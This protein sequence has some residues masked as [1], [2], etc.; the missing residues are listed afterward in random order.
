MPKDPA[1]LIYIDKWLVSTKS[2][3]AA[4][5]GWY[6]SLILVQYDRGGE[7]PNDIEELAV[8]CDVRFSEFETFKQMW[9]QVLKQ[10]FKQTES[11]ALQNEIAFEILQKRESFKDKRAQSGKIGVVVKAA[12]A[13]GYDFNH[14]ET[15]KRSDLSQYYEAKNQQMLQQMLQQNHKLYINV[16]V[17]KDLIINK[18]G[19]S[20]FEHYETEIEIEKDIMPSQVDN[21]HFFLECVKDDIWLERVLMA[22][23]ISKKQTLLDYL[24]SFLEHLG[25]DAK[26]HT[27]RTEFIRHFNNWMRTQI[28]NGKQPAIKYEA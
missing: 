21:L 24:A 19:V 23:R 27:K 16:D 14:I 12:K 5:R 15:L 6:L 22:N 28:S 18:D 25:A 10:K 26:Q 9:E 20:L 4:A 17:D 7:L 3:P 13:V 2:M 11:G 1:A 8:I